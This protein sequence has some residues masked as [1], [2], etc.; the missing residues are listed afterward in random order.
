MKAP[1]FDAETEAMLSKL[2][3]VCPL[4]VTDEQLKY[5]RHQDSPGA[6]QCGAPSVWVM[7]C[8]YDDGKLADRDSWCGNGGHMS[9]VVNGRL[10]YEPCGC[11]IWKMV[12]TGVPRSDA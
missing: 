10:L 7:E 5:C 8:Y 12:I 6:A 2:P 9:A 11:C 4:P 3:Q 1:G